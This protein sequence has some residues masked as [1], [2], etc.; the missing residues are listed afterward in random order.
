MPLDL[1]AEVI[2][3]AFGLTQSLP[4]PT[5][6]VMQTRAAPSAGGLYPLELYVICSDITGLR[7]GAYHYAP[8][9]HTLEPLRDG[10]PPEMLTTFLLAEPFVRNANAIVFLTAVFDRTLHKYGPRG[11]RY[12][13][14][15]AGHVAQNLCLLAMERSLGSLC[16]G[17]FMDGA[18]NRFLRIDGVEEAAVYGIAIGYPGDVPAAA[19]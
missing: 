8:L 1:M 15:E 4:L 19:P 3:G 14:L 17:G 2:G 7:D 6:I 5:G 9:E 13:L 10:V 12:I 18:A 11:Y 16:L